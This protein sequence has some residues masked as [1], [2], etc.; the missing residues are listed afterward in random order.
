[1]TEPRY[2]ARG[3]RPMNLRIFLDAGSIE[4]FADHGRWAG[5]KRIEGFEPVRSVRLEAAEGYVT[6]GRIFALKL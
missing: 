5:T 3:A 2:I 1:M 6:S 4:V